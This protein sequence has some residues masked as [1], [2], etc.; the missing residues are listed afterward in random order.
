MSFTISEAELSS[1][2]RNGGGQFVPAT[3][4]PVKAPPEPTPSS[5]LR[6]ISDQLKHVVAAV[7][8][9]AKPNDHPAKVLGELKKIATTLEDA[10]PPP[11]PV[12]KWDLVIERGAD[13][14]MKRIRATAVSLLLSLAT[15][16]F[17]WADPTNATVNLAWDYA[18]EDLST[19]LT[20]KI[21][22]S[23]TNSTPSTNWMV[24]TNVVGTNLTASVQIV[25]GRYFFSAT[26]S[27]AWGESLFSNVAETQGLPGQPQNLRLNGTSKGWFG[28]WFP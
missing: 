16:A 12:R 19:N 15:L 23:P 8:T 10:T 5:L 24:L 28:E 22:G 7:E 3:R 18:P 11:D 17:A 25:P 13:G 20:F 2:R 9:P 27:N 26:A 4:R 21:Y 1:I 6:Q 14:K